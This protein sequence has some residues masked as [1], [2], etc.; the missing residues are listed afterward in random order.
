MVRTLAQNKLEGRATVV[1]S[2]GPLELVSDHAT[3]H[4]YVI[5]SSG[6]RA[7][8]PDDR[9]VR[10]VADLQPHPHEQFATTR[11]TTIDHQRAVASAHGPSIV[12]GVARR[13]PSE[14]GR[15]TSVR[16]I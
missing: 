7:D 1:V 8:D 9:S 14:V 2:R 16:H 6:I 3:P 10:T 5:P 15:E 13:R 4:R 12:P 11:V